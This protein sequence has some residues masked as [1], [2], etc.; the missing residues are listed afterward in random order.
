MTTPHTLLSH[1][2][3]FCR[4]LRDEG[5]LIGPQETA[6]AFR[7]I[8]LVNIMDRG[9]VYWALR[10]V[11]LSNPEEAPTF[12][13]LFQLLWSFQPMPPATRRTRGMSPGGGMRE[14]RAPRASP[15][16]ESYQ[17]PTR[18][19]LETTRT[20]ASAVELNAR[21]DLSGL[22]QHEEAELH[23]IAARI[24]RALATRPSRRRRRHPRKG[25]P[26]L[27]GAFRLSLSTGGE[28]L[29]LPRLRRKPRVPRLVILLDVSGSMERHTALLLRLLY[30]VFRHTHRIEAL[31][32]STSVTRVTH[33]LQAPSFQETLQG[34]G[35]A[36]EHWS[37][38]TKIGPA[39][40]TVN[41]QYAALLDR[42]TSVFLL[43]D[44]WDTGDPA[45]LARELRRM[46][47]KVRRL[48]WLNPLIGTT[49]YQPL[50]RGLL[51]AAPAVDRFASARDLAQLKRLPQLLRR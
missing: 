28:P 3:L 10:T 37:G 20:G 26:D 43:S 42:Y 24:V 7:A 35:R 50:T 2:T 22:E 4:R 47:R 12:D 8:S 21:R 49:D 27:R 11:L 13:Q 6:D 29:R 45:D 51:A 14:F 33:I 39:I 44:G 16:K 31:V 46:R 40:R 15:S 36:V 30:A 23:R 1:L 34:L 32:F 41:T 48:V 25:A 18:T 9:H 38:G 19:L 5:L 17:P